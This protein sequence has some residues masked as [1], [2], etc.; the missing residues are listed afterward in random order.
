MPLNFGL[1]IIYAFILLVIFLIVFINIYSLY[2]VIFLRREKYYAKLKVI[3]ATEKQIFC[4]IILE[5][6]ILLIITVLLSFLIINALM[7]YITDISLNSLDVLNFVNIRYLSNSIYVYLIPSALFVI[8]LF[9]VIFKM[10]KF[11]SSIVIVEAL[12]S[13][14]EFLNKNN[15]KEELDGK[16][17]INQYIYMNIKKRRKDALLITLAITLLFSILISSLV[18]FN[19]IKYS[20][21]N[22]ETL[23]ANNNLLVKIEN[24]KNNNVT[25]NQ[26]LEFISDI[27]G[28]SEVDDIVSFRMNQI[29]LGMILSPND[30]KSTTNIKQENNK[31]IISL[32]V[33]S[34]GDKKFKEISNN[35]DVIIIDNY[36][37][38]SIL[39]KRLSEVILCADYGSDYKNSL[40]DESKCSTYR[41][42]L[43]TDDERYNYNWLDD[44]LT[45]IVSDQLFDQLHLNYNYFG[46]TNI[47][48]IDDA[49]YSDVYI[50]TSDVTKT[51][52]MIDSF[53]N[54]GL[55]ILFEDLN[56]MKENLRNSKLAILVVVGMINILISISIIINILNIILNI[57]VYRKK[58]FLTLRILG[59]KRKHITKIIFLETA[60][61]L[62]KG[63][64][65]GFLVGISF[66]YLIYMALK[67][68][69]KDSIFIFD[70]PFAVIFIS[71]IC[72]L[73]FLYASVLIMSNGIKTRK[74]WNRKQIT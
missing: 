28:I 37:G 49:K 2:S 62:I 18:F 68:F 1:M 39:E 74:I 25:N 69:F 48:Y 64:I 34:I 5:N 40:I 36:N 7:N 56:E 10:K 47:D 22:I 12:K 20:T 27:A 55:N 65:M 31:I 67:L 66:G 52:A 29:L 15:S 3:G 23:T 24:K 32:N 60:Y 8:S 54:L 63:I 21:K 42:I 4:G 11:L 61:Y 17:I 43:I 59:M 71:I 46:E 14:K 44:N 38:K 50:K 70:I 13:K 35:K 73:I 19:I 30:L 16:N 33:L 26:R 6:I 53:N 57:V 72:V 9:L 41:N 58:E 45:I 51:I